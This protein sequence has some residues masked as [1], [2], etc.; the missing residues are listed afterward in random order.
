MNAKNNKKRHRKIGMFVGVSTTLFSVC[1]PIL[2]SV[3]YA[4]E[5]EATNKILHPLPDA[6]SAFNFST[7]F[8]STTNSPISGAPE[9]EV[10]VEE[11]TTPEETKPSEGSTS[12]ETG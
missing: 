8:A 2:Q 9:T 12:N 6:T 3:V 11:N 5:V 1:G 7:D 10:P 4:E